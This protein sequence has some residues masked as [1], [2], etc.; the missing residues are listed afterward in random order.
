MQFSPLKISDKRIVDAYL[1][2]WGGFGTDYAFASWFSWYDFSKMSFAEADDVLYIRG[3][4][5]GE[6]VFLSPLCKDEKYPFAVSVLRGVA[7]EENLPLKIVFAAK[8]QIEV[9]NNAVKV[10]N[11]AITLE[12]AKISEEKDGLLVSSNRDNSEYVY[13]A[14]NLINLS[15][16]HYHSKRNFVTRF[17]KQYAYSFETYT[18]EMFDDAVR[19]INTWAAEKSIDDEEEIGAFTMMLKHLSELSG[20]ADVLKIDGKIV[21]IAVGDVSANGVGEVFF[22]KGDTE[23]D[24]I[25]AAIN[26]MFAEKHFSGIKYV[27]RQ[28]DMGISGLRTAKLSYKPEF[29]ADKFTITESAFSQLEDL[30]GKSFPEDS[31]NF[32]SFYFSNKLPSSVVTA[33]ISD[34]TIVSALYDFW[35]GL[36]AGSAY[37]PTAFVTAAATLPEKRGQG[38]ISEPIK[39]LFTECFPMRQPLVILQ[40][41]KRGFYKKFGFA[42]LTFEG[43][44]TVKSKNAKNPLTA[45]ESG[46]AA[47]IKRAY[48]AF[49]ASF[50]FFVNRT[51]W[52]FE[53]RLEELF[54]ESGKAYVVYDCERPLGYYFLIENQVAEMALTRNQANRVYELDGKQAVF[55]G[56]RFS[57]AEARIVD[58]Y[59]FVERMRFE[60]DF[61]LRFRLRDDLVKINDGVFKLTANGGVGKLE[62]CDVYDEDFTIDSF[63]TYVFTSGKVVSGKGFVVDR[64]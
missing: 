52:D 9:L 5:R 1:K 21:G 4:I 29:L 38:L 30:Y 24:G 60:K 56:G 36:V 7:K 43:K 57:G 15:G 58:I 50:A 16:K 20:F 35:K 23:F 40:P 61:V 55:A 11:G 26:Q 27:N 53:R 18:D 42:P 13:L 48:D 39:R 59:R 62:T 34:G 51:E 6:Q 28:E 33:Y 22:E 63:L 12:G 46:S 8:N 19:L 25:Y 44:H 45:K 3:E 32:R 37:V 31:E 41:F 49:C 17:K 10:P 47:E 54:S 64:Y 2:K 14:E